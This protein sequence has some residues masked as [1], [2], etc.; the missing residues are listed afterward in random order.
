[1]TAEEKGLQGADY[2]ANNP[3][4]PASSMVANLNTDMFLML[5]PFTDATTL[6]AE[7][8]SLGPIAEQSLKTVGLKMTPDPAPD[9]VRFVR[10]DQYAFIKQGIPSITLIS[11]FA[12]SDPLVKGEE[13]NREW[14]RNIYHG[15]E[16]ESTQNMHWES[17]EKLV[18]AAFLIGLEVAND[19]TRAA[20]NPDDFFGVTFG[21]NAK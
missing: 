19:P 12:S 17:G 14:L 15:P 18:R 21:K 6:G 5:F 8:S 10:S 2:F 7:N 16:D 4:I 1:M 13:V 9:E 11:G 3:T 20:W